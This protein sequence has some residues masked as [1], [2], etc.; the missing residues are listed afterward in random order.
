MDNTVSVLE[1]VHRESSVS[2]VANSGLTEVSHGSLDALLDQTHGSNV[3]LRSTEAVSG[4]L[5]SCVGEK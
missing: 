2:L 5:N 1:H 4:C 3:S